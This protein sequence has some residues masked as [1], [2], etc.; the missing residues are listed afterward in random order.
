MIYDYEKREFEVRKT[1]LAEKFEG[2]QGFRIEYESLV[3]TPYEVN[4]RVIGYLFVPD[5]IKTNKPVVFL[6]GLGNKNLI[7][8]S[9]YPREFA[10]NGIVSYLM[11]LPYHFER[12][13]VGMESG[14][15]FLVDDMDDS[16]NDFRQAVIDVRTSMDYLEREGYSSGKFSIM[17]VSFGGMVSTIAMGVDTRI[18]EGIFVVTGGNYL[19]L[20][21]KGF[22]TR[23]TRRKYEMNSNLTIYGCNEEKCAEYH[24]NYRDYIEKLTSPEDIEVVPYEKGCFLFDPLTFARFVRD[25]KV[26]LYNALFDEAIPRKAAEELWE[27]MGRPERH[28]LFAEHVTSILYRRG[29]RD[30]AL[31]LFL[32]GK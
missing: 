21:W 25:R 5:R 26:I 12:T 3:K 18:K 24:K 30:R 22:A 9:W 13:P 6:H 14:K 1:A 8:L 20:V 23:F 15:K 4:N 7:P 27:V 11:I 32:K 29:I 28:W 19:Y 10:R 31:R 16:L 2:S 17:G